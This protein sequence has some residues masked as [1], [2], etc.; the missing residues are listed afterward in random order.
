MTFY[1]YSATGSPE[2][3]YALGTINVSSSSGAFGSAS[4]VA[5]FS[6]TITRASGGSALGAPFT[7]PSNNTVI[8]QFSL[9]FSN[10]FIARLQITPNNGSSETINLQRYAFDPDTVTLK[11]SLLGQWAMSYAIASGTPSAMNYMDYFWLDKVG[12]PVNAGGLGLVSGAN[13]PRIG[14]ECYS[15]TATNFPGQCLIAVAGSDGNVFESFI[16]NNPINEL[17]GTYR[18]NGS[19]NYYVARGMRIGSKAGPS[20]FGFTTTSAIITM[21]A[22]MDANSN[23]ES[24]QAQKIVLDKMIGNANEVASPL[25]PLIALPSPEDRALQ[26]SYAAKI[27]AAVR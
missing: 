23:S 9:V 20:A 13:S 14:A 21:A 7:A 16:V 18:L 4:G 6:G 12:A 11:S 17:R 19:T 22:P 5:S 24:A 27:L 2:W 25:D 1:R 3:Y 15:T 8:G 10:S 26:A